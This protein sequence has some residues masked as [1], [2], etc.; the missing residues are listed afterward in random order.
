MG[1]KQD[2]GSLRRSR[3]R[4]WN[5]RNAVE[6]N[7][8]KCFDSSLPAM[9]TTKPIEGLTSLSLT[10]FTI[11]VETSAT[12]K[13]VGTDGHD[14]G[15]DAV[16]RTPALAS[17]KLSANTAT[18]CHVASAELELGTHDTAE[19]WRKGEVFREPDMDS[20]VLDVHPLHI[21]CDLFILW[22]ETKQVHL[23]KIHVIIHEINRETALGWITLLDALKFSSNTLCSLL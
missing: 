13:E 8:V 2:G 16:L 5:I 18:K 1:E 21:N 12:F 14:D 19:G 23:P 11:T 15:L 10:V 3:K 22:I 7:G 6:M 9:V 17:K 20:D 4:A